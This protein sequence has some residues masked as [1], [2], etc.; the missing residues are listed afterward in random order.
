[1]LY[2][3]HVHKDEHSAYGARF[4]DFPGCFAAADELQDFARAAQE[5]VKAPCFGDSSP[6]TD[7]T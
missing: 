4:P 6:L 3:L 5:T 2:P 1:M 7:H